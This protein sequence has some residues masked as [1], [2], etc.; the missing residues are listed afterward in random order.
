VLRATNVEGSVLAQFVVD[1]FG[2]ADMGEFKVLKSDHDLFTAT[3]MN[4][5]PMIK[6]YPAELNGH[7][8]KQLVQMPFEFSL[9]KNG[10]TNTTPRPGIVK[11]NRADG[12]IPVSDNQ[13]YFEF[14]VEKTVTARAGTAAAPKYPAELRA[15]NIEGEVLAQFTVD[16]TG[17]PVIETFKVLKSTHDL[18]TQA[19]RSALPTMRFDPAQVGG[20][21]VRQLVQM[22]FTFNL[23]K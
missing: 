15:A 3:V 22:P 6:F 14:Q 20:R 7:K 5:L 18:F 9:L 8:V 10:V 23:S 17:V 4:T 2:R 12:P 13:T 19:V 21:P 1:T 11:L 16:T